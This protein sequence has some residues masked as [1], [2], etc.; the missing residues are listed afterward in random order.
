LLLLII[1]EVYII[2]PMTQPT[3]TETVEQGA[4]SVFLVLYDVSRLFRRDFHRRTRVNGTTRAQWQVLVTLSRNEGIR[5]ITLADLLEIE[6]ITLVRLLDRLEESGL[7]ERRLDPT[8]RRARTLHLTEAARPLIAQ[9]REIG[10]QCRAAG[11]VGF[12]QEEQAQL[13]A[14]LQRVRKNFAE[15]TGAPEGE[16]LAGERA[17]G[18]LSG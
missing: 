17:K 7:V 10:Q 16:R 5:Q 6:P 8:D 15:R 11:L 13:L 1:V 2:L 14:L 18:V 9:T 12:S 4:E 3:S